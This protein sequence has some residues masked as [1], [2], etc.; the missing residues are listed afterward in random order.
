MKGC[1]VSEMGKER[2]TGFLFENQSLL[3]SNY[4]LVTLDKRPKSLESQFTLVLK[5]G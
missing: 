4:I 3:R 5:K 1:S 2:E